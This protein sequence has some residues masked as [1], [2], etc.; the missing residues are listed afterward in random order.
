MKCLI[1]FVTILIISLIIICTRENNCQDIEHY[2]EDSYKITHMQEFEL[3][4]LLKIIHTQC[5]KNNIDYTMC[6][7]TIL[8][9]IRHKNF[10]PWDDDADLIIFKRDIDKFENINWATYGCVI[11]KHMIGYK[12]SFIEG[13]KAVEN[14]EKQ[15]WNFPFVDIFIFDKFNDKYTFTNENC[16]AFWPDDYL[17]EQDIYPL[18]LYKFGDIELYGVNNAYGYLHR[19][20]KPGWEINAKITHN[21]HTGKNIKPINFVIQN[22]LKN[23]KM[24][25]IN[26]LWVFNSK[27]N[28]K[29][30]NKYQ[31][32][33]VVIFI[34][35]DVLDIYLPNLKTTDLQNVNQL[36]IDKYGG[37]ILNL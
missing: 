15:E 31:D 37:Y 29:I 34:Y 27:N 8:G 10:I 5:G 23:N 18:K 28:K 22:Y 26:Y 1:A 6:G 30:I 35:N 2:F 9:A 17:Y 12:I 14:D 11:N 19:Y 4:K 25:Q 32:K 33:Y 3:K 16:R 36:L 20:F 7:G 13:E 21:H 24:Q